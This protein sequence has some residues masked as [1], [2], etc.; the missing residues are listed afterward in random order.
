MNAE[1]Y[2]MPGQKKPFAIR[3]PFLDQPQSS[4]IK[5]DCPVRF[6]PE[7]G[8]VIL[9][10]QRYDQTGVTW[11]KLKTPV[12]L[13]GI[14]ATLKAEVW[15]FLEGKPISLKEEWY[16]ARVPKGFKS[17][18]EFV[19]DFLN[20]KGQQALSIARN[21]QKEKPEPFYKTERDANI[22]PWKN[23]CDAT[24][25]LLEK[26][27]P[28]LARAIKSGKVNE[29][30]A[31]A[32]VADEIR[33]SGFGCAGFSTN[34]PEFVAMISDAWQAYDRRTKRKSKVDS[35]DFHLAHP[36]V[37]SKYY[38]MK[39][40]QIAPL[41]SKETQTTELSAGA[42]EKRIERLGLIQPWKRGKP[43]KE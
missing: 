3:F 8:A 25:R 6:A 42:I 30:C 1:R 26:D 2:T 23:A 24:L 38:C 5:K 4:E 29:A 15:G 9:N 11:V 7:L 13:G 43:V 28:A 14:R 36:R 31:K 18:A 35:I 32:F 12:E 40:E 37:W 27:N 10:F 20:K 16:A 33:R 39:P 17:F 34:D 22:D 19:S 41:L 21:H